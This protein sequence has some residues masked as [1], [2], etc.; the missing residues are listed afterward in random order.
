MT[1]TSAPG[2][3]KTKLSHDGQ[4][5]L[6]IRCRAAQQA[7]ALKARAAEIESGIAV[8]DLVYARLLGSDCDN[9]AWL[10]LSVAAN[11]LQDCLGVAQ[12]N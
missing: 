12:W 1:N 8:C 9:N 11:N 7:A 10:A 6:D 5:Y 3:T 4:E 2:K